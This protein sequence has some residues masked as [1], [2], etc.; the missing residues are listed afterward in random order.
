MLNIRLANMNTRLSPGRRAGFTL[1]ELLVVIAI[2]G[3]LASLLLPALSRAKE[4]ARTVVCLSNLRQL[5]LAGGCTPRTTTT[6][7]PPTTRP[8][9]ED[10]TAKTTPPGLWAIFGTVGLTAPTWTT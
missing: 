6:G 4:S 9:T 2:I 5:N 7:S 3:I 10:L 8:I 1:I